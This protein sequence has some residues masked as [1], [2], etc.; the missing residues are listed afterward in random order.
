[1]KYENVILEMQERIQALEKQV[2]ELQLQVGAR[3]ERGPREI[4]VGNDP[5]GMKR[6]PPYIKVTKEMADA[7]YLAGKEAYEN[8]AVEI[9]AL[10]DRVSV[11]TGM[12][13]NNAL[14]SIFA[15]V[16]LL[17]GELYKRGISARATDLYFEHILNDYGKGGLQ[18]A[19]A[20]MRLHIEYRQN[21]NHNMERLE[22]ICDH[23]QEKV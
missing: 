19:I 15:V 16:A 4:R 1:M 11:E 17:R 2:N 18:K 23:Y 10:A 6:K 5:F 20:A 3:M 8:E 7:C 14:M 21:L 9:G 12:N 22:L 13:R